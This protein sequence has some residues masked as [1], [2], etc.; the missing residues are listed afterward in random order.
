MPRPTA[1]FVALGAVLLAACQDTGSTYSSAEPDV[2]EPELG[3]EAS[4]LFRQGELTYS[5]H[6]NGL[7]RVLP[8]EHGTC[9]MAVLL[10][11]GEAP[12]LQSLA[13][14]FN[15]L[16]D[17][18]A[19]VRHMAPD[20]GEA[21]A[22]MTM[23]VGEA[24]LDDVVGWQHAVWHLSGMQTCAVDPGVIDLAIDQQRYPPAEGDEVQLRCIPAPDAT[25]TLQTET[26]WPVCIQGT[27]VE[28]QS[29]CAPLREAGDWVQIECPNY[30]E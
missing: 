26:T 3:R 7:V 28:G 9:E 29:A 23:L 27:R 17:A 21:G 5:L 10:D 16:S 18:R 25:V 12:D 8:D 2:H 30:G 14:F 20:V 4:L 13:D 22:P 19:S 6:T 11:M 24:E 1:S 15:P